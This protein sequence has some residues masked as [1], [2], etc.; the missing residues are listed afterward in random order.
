MY[1]R[2]PWDSPFDENGE[3]VPDRYSGWV[4]NSETNYLRDLSYGNHTDSKTY[5]FFGNF[6]FDIK[7]TDWLTFRS[8]NSYKYVNHYYHSYTDPRS[9]SAQGV[10]GRIN[11]YQSN[12]TRRYTNQLLSFNKMFGK[13][14]VDAILAYEF[15]DAS[16]KATNA[17]G[18]GFTPGFEVLD[19]TALAVD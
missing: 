16:D 9:S 1:K 3:L 11:E 13:H 18:T 17:I 4:D 12:S 8:V 2:L 14:S 7:I 5:E 15:K 10:R 19:V 6:D